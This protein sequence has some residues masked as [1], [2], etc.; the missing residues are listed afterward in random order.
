[1]NQLLFGLARAVVDTFDLPEPVVEIGS[2]QVAGQE[3]IGDLRT[4]F[5]GKTYVGTDMRVGPGVDC[6]EDVEHLGMAD[7][8][9]GT[10]VAMSVLE[11][12][13]HFWR[14]L[15]E[16]RRVLRPDGAL[17]LACPF[18]FRVHAFPSDYWRFTVEALKLMLASYPS[19]V[20]GYHG[21]PRRPAH[22]W[23]LAFREGRP[24]ITDAQLARLRDAIGRHARQPMR[25]GKRLRYQ[26]GQLLCGRRPFEPFLWQNHWDCELLNVQG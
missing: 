16:I 5:G 24:A 23:A 12:V 26:L 13:R 20:V 6:V 25:R 19:K 11:H 2:Y 3:S 18:H 10:V 1:M 22:V 9:V 8:S 21:S 14:G 17:L 15:D 4:L 7:A